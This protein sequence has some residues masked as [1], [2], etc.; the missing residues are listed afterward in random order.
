MLL[1][2]VYILY[3]AGYSGSYLNWAIHA[4]DDDLCKQVVT[5]PINLVDNSKFGGIGTSHLHHRVPT[6]QGIRQHLAWMIYNKPSQPKIYIINCDFENIHEVVSSILS[7]DKD[8]TFIVIHDNNDSDIRSYGQINCAT[9][10]P[11]FFAAKYADNGKKLDFDPFNCKTD[12]GF[13]N[14]VAE[15]KVGFT[16]MYPLDDTSLDRIKSYHMNY[17]NWFR[18]RNAANPHEVSSDY[19]LD[20]ECFPSAC[21]FQLSC[22]DIVSKNFLSILNDILEESQCLSSFD[23]HR[24]TSVHQEY[25]EIQQN[26]KWFSSLNIWKLQ[27]HVDEYL[28]SHSVIQGMIISRIFNDCEL[29]DTDPVTGSDPLGYMAWQAFYYRIKDSSWP[30][31]DHEQDFFLLPKK[32][33]TELIKKYNYVPRFNADPERAKCRSA[34]TNWKNLSLEEINTIYQSFRKNFNTLSSVS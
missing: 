34:L 20:K 9:K 18:V 4:S 32:V 27:G 22:L 28:L 3:P 21:I 31:C 26:L 33:Q 14:L 24:I 6:H 13:R 8:P 2:N 25:I 5:S 15:N 30:N 12:L 29:H 7:Y 17:L 23:T 11:L 19:Y 10:W 1:K 16:N